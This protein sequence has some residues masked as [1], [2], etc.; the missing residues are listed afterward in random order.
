MPIPWMINILPLRQRTHYLKVGKLFV[1]INILML[2]YY[3]Q[4]HC[5]HFQQQRQ[6]YKKKFSFQTKHNSHNLQP[7]IDSALSKNKQK[8]IDLWANFYP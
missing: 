7:N 2:L 3:L 4:T 6:C 5:P 8:A 1:L